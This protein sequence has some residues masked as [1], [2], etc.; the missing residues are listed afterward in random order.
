MWNVNSV[1]R[2]LA[3]GVQR[4]ALV[5]LLLSCVSGVE[6]MLSCFCAWGQSAA[7]PENLAAA[8]DSLEIQ[9]LLELAR[10][11]LQQ[12]DYPRADSLASQA[13]YLAEDL[14]QLHLQA[15]A[16]RLIG[17]AKRRLDRYDE[18]LSAHARSLALA[19]RLN[20]LYLKTLAQGNLALIYHSKGFYEKAVV[21]NF[22]ALKGYEE[23]NDNSGAA[24][25]LNN[26]AIIYSD[27]KRYDDALAYYQR[28]RLLFE[29]IADTM[30]SIS[31]M[32]STA[33]LYTHLGKPTLAFDSIAI[34][35]KRAQAFGDSMLIAD[36][37]STMGDLYKKENPRFAIACKHDA[38]A[39]YQ[40]FSD[41]PSQTL[42][43]RDIAALLLSRN[44]ATQALDYAT[45]SLNLASD[46]GDRTLLQ[47]SLFLLSEIYDVLGN[48]AQ[49][50]AAYKK[51]SAIKDSLFTI[52]EQK[53]IAELREQYESEKKEKEIQFLEQARTLERVRSERERT[54][55]AALTLVLTV[56]VAGVGTALYVKQKHQKVLEEK[57]AQIEA[58][59]RIVEAQR[60]ELAAANQL[61]ND[62]LAIA[63]HDLKNPLQTIMGFASLLKEKLKNDYE[64][65][66]VERIERASQRML[67]LII[68]LIDTAA[69]ESGKI[70]L[71]KEPLDLSDLARA[72]T[73]Q[74]QPNASQKNIVLHLQLAELAMT[75]GDKHRLMEVLDNLVSNAIKYSPRNKNV[76]ITTMVHANHVRCVVKDE[77]QGLSEE[78]LKKLFGRFQR[79]SARPTGNESSTGLGL[80]IVKQLVE[81]HGGRVWAESEGKGKG[82]AFCV[83]LPKENSS[84]RT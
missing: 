79:L 44:Q 68:E 63:S 36:A 18:A 51:A 40:H 74:N 2:R 21:H 33:S 72:V 34:A 19:E 64:F 14:Q 70:E 84:E 3:R 37:L 10:H 53:R 1:R 9:R 75:I 16:L 30:K 49:A 31:T 43:L 60:D 55:F 15:H 58:Q 73:E 45:K 38:L 24:I 83:E 81:L 42:V 47:N 59:K 82:S 27:Q 17:I 7:Q 22:L 65:S 13:L 28:A 39:I 57:N 12:T 50:L 8:H 61:K 5:G 35:L 11:A 71:H 32:I 6:L 48:A 69:I 26:L 76:F 54:I 23:L 20:D 29:E 25:T 41:I 78:D 62:L 80:S 52:E 56:A 46:I 77:G 66:M 4:Y 67:R